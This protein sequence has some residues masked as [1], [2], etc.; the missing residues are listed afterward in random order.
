MRDIRKRV[1]V[2]ISSRGFRGQLVIKILKIISCV[3]LSLRDVG[4]DDERPRR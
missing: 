2:L 3:V 1:M 4:T